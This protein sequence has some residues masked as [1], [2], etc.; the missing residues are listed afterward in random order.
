ML[1]ISNNNYSHLSKRDPPITT[2]APSSE[3]YSLRTILLGFLSVLALLI[4][5]SIIFFILFKRRR[6]R[7]LHR[8]HAHNDPKLKPLQLAPTTDDDHHQDSNFLG[9]KIDTR[10]LSH[11]TVL[12]SK[13]S[14]S[15]EKEEK[16]TDDQ[17]S[18]R[19]K[20]LRPL[21]LSASF[22]VT[23]PFA[24]TPASLYK[25][26][27]PKDLSYL[28]N[29]GGLDGLLLGLHT[30]EKS[31]LVD[32]KENLKE[33]DSLN[34]I[35]L[36]EILKEQQKEPPANDEEEEKNES[37]NLY[38]LNHNFDVS[39]DSPFYERIRIFGKNV[40]PEK[41]AKTIF[42]LMWMAMKEQILII[43]T[44]AAV[45][46]LAL[47]IYEDYGP[48]NH[49]PDE[50]KIKWVEG[51]AIIVA[52]IIVVL[53]GS[54][55][56]WQ[57]ERQFRK[58]NAKK[59]DRNVKVTR[60]GKEMLLSVYEVL[61]GDILHLEPGD[62]IAVDGVLISSQNLRC[63][64]SAATGESDAVKKKSYYEC[65]K[66]SLIAG[67]NVGGDDH[68]GN[69]A[70]KI[71]KHIKFDPFVISGSKVLEGVGKYVVTGVGI[72]SFNGRTL[73]ALRKD[74]ENTPLQDKLN[75]LAER[76]AKLG[77]TAAIIM[78]LTLLIK[79]FATFHPS[80][81]A[82]TIIENLVT[83]I[84]STVTIVVVAI[85]EALA[86]ATTR[87][88]K[89][90]NLV[91]VL[92]ACET[93]GNATTICSDKTGTLTQN[94]MTVVTGIIGS[95]VEFQRQGYKKNESLLKDPK[96]I[97]NLRESLPTEI[98]E[99]LDESISVNS[100]AFQGDELVNGRN[101]FVG[102]K[103]ETALLDFL[104]DLGLD[105][106]N[107]L[108]S[109]ANVV[110]LFPFSSER[111][112]MGIL[113]KKEDKWRF[114]IKGA[115]EVLLSKSESVVN[116]ATGD[117]IDLNNININNNNGSGDIS[118]GSS[119][120]MRQLEQLIESFAN[121][122]LRT[123]TVAYRD[124][125]QWPPK[126]V[127][128]LN[129][130]DEVKYEYLAE[131]LTLIAI[132]GIEDPLRDGVK[133]A[134][135]DCKRAGVYVRMVTGDNISTARSIAIQCGPDFRKLSSDK[136]QRIIPKLQ[137]LARSSPEDK[138]ILVGKLKELGEIVAVTGDG[139]NDGP[140]LKTA[141]VGFSMG[142]AGTE[143]AKEASSIILMDDNFSSLVKA[144]M[145]GRCV[146]D[147]VKKF[148]Q[149][150]LTVN[151][152]AVLLTFISAVSSNEEKAV[153]SAV[154]LLWVNLI[155]DTLAALA[156]AT[157]PPTKELLNRNPEPRNSPLIN[158]RQIIIVTFGGAAFQ[159]APLNI[160][161]WLI[162]IGLGFLSIPI[163]FII[164]LIPDEFLK[165][166]IIKPLTPKL[167]IKMILSRS[168]SASKGTTSSSTT[169]KSSSMK[170]LT[171]SDYSSNTVAGG[172]NEDTFEDQE[173]VINAFKKVESQL[174][175]FKTLRGG[176]FK[177]H[178]GGNG[179]DNKQEKRSEG[180]HAAAM[181]PSLMS[182]SIVGVG[183]ASTSSNN[184]SLGRKFRRNKN[185]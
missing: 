112:A 34:P 28:Y 179:V 62:I 90:N 38:Q 117:V 21:S 122:S 116:I 9:Y 22:S 118:S 14:G 107:D 134:V 121:D 26:V 182:V 146:N 136:M 123:I 53:V 32:I 126:D 29:I 152:T 63:D 160:I 11:P 108:R 12:V 158:F 114:H 147:S 19:T 168:T 84:I 60:N 155:M 153:L 129:D 8:I 115:S 127:T 2:D 87:M 96:S 33:R 48:Q 35:T 95:S 174:K 40:L 144:I 113:I 142:I 139:T 180:F 3:S 71:L 151:V 183:K 25:F 172:D 82:A 109:Q 51:V 4:L 157:D 55:N 154:Q 167:L 54:L 184:N 169:R 6:R 97:E 13:P 52:I 148:L 91:R 85:P 36:E 72:Y 156:L 145:W 45:V 141:D 86:Y 18:N 105:D 67:N 81:G 101:A 185:G 143:V 176:R 16:E 181:L 37:H 171:N 42:E 103:T 65:E 178:F 159:T 23:N 1:L 69:K 15:K 66:E 140:A 39:E 58:L 31:G 119:Y 24:Y 77:G 98:L 162:C 68:D 128:A 89:D 50:P 78:L 93:M 104:L 102:S 20:G 177:A 83:I 64:E 44:I 46:S 173:E 161:Q 88:L 130:D 125:E 43:L 150:Q 41:K 138:R 106:F 124:F 49:R 56:D 59:E 163:G 10:R 73:M 132:F 5:L 100:T 17:R 7:Q 61:V 99:L 137:V 166:N 75:D 76:I 92:S 135:E 70:K 120:N 79:Y 47:G 27:D 74:P 131:K 30:N 133:E 111:K 110:Q 165:K 164:R 149:F 94:K 57:K 80:D 175:V 170:P